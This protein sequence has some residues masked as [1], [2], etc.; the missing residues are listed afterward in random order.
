MMGLRLDDFVSTSGQLR[1]GFSVSRRNILQLGDALLQVFD[2]PSG[3]AVL[4]VDV[5]VE[6]FDAEHVAMVGHGNAFHAVLHGFVHQAADAG[7]A[8]QQGVLGF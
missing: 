3:A 2:F 6:F 5:V 4:L 8:V 1:L 7:L